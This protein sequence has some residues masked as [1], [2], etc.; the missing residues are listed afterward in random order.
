MG[1]WR[2]RLTQGECGGLVVD[3]SVEVELQRT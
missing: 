1:V 2:V 3:R